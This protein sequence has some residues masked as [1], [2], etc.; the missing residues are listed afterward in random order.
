MAQ[1]FTN[2]ASTTTASAI[3]NVATSITLATGKGAL[4][5]SPTGGDFF[6]VTLVGYTGATET[7][8]EIVKCTARTGDVLT[9]VRAQEGTTAVA[10]AV[11]TVLELRVTAGTLGGTGRTMYE[12]DQTIIS[13]TTVTAGKNAMSAGPITISTGVTVTVPTG[14]TW[15]IV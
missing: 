6:L 13:D 4:F 10:W 5:P 3:T 12:N 1:L 11:G 2:N 7:S 15:T 14:S 8:W 9:V